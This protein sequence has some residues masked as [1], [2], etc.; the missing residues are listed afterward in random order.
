MRSLLTAL[1]LLAIHS[2]VVVVVVAVVTDQGQASLALR[3]AEHMYIFVGGAHFSG[4]YV[5]ML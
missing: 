4:M 2:T 1:L 3:K 5:C